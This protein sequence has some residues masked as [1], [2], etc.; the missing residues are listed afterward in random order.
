MSAYK[1]AAQSNLTNNT[2]TKVTF[3]T[4]VY[5][6]GEDFAS[7]TFTVP[8]NGYYF[9]RGLV[10]FD[11]ADMVADKLYNSAIYVDGAVVQYG[12]AHSTMASAALGVPVAK[13]FYLTAGQTVELYARQVSGGNT[14]DIG[15]GASVTNLDI[16]LVRPA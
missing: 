12:F 3:D 13:M 2:W 16:T 7:S 11:S 15:Y 6:T 10:T 1:S 4:E 5:D 9:V 14:I 8:V